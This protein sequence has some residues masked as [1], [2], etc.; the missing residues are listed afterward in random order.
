MRLGEIGCVPVCEVYIPVRVSARSC[1]YRCFLVVTFRLP[2]PRQCF[3]F[4]GICWYLPLFLINFHVVLVSGKRKV[5]KL[6]F[7]FD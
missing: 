3:H 4:T 5:V 1:M 2:G 7:E 6:T